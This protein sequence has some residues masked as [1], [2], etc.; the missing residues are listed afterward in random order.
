MYSI[1]IRIKSILN[2]INISK[3]FRITSKQFDIPLSTIYRWYKIYKI[4][5][6][7]G[8]KKVNT[9][10]HR[11][12]KITSDIKDRISKIIFDYPYC[13]IKD[14]IDKLNINVSITSIFNVLRKMKITIKKAINRIEYKGKDLTNERNEFIE[15]VKNIKN[16]ICLDE[17]GIQ[18]EMRNTLG[19][20]KRGTKIYMKRESIHYRKQYSCLM[21]ICPKS[22]TK[23]KLYKDAINRDILT[24][25]INDNKIFFQNK[26][27][28][29]DNV[30]FHKSKCV[31][32]ALK[33]INC[34]VLYTPPYSPY[35]NPIEESFSQIKR[36]IRKIYSPDIDYKK[37]IN[38]AINQ[39]SLENI[40]NYYNHAFF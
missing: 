5:G 13:S 3:S 29:L 30:S 24:D 33:Q 1:D 18:Y 38:D 9:K 40:S 34:N 23:Y 36:Y 10:C 17:T 20:S 6:F 8:L 11:N 22:G 16:L 32:D 2:Y 27:L 7:I 4:N 37:R 28:L 31:I 19:R 39:I 26:T 15:K 35:L 25:F 14:I 21:V 12:R